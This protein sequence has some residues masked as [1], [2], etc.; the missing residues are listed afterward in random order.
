MA[1]QCNHIKKK[2]KPSFNGKDHII[3]NTSSDSYRELRLTRDF[4]SS[5]HCAI[6]TQ[7]IFT[8]TANKNIV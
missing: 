5:L 8:T 1:Q 7:F 6:D 3:I 2:Q 4:I